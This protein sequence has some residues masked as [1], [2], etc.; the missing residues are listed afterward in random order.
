MH[1]TNV[2]ATIVRHNYGFLTRPAIAPAIQSHV[3]GD[4]GEWLS[5]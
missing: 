4:T 2:K 3:T 5:L 1:Q